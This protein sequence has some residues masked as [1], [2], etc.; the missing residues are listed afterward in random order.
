MLQQL[1]LVLMAR[2]KKNTADKSIVG[3]IKPVTT[4]SKSPFRIV[5]NKGKFILYHG[6]SVRQVFMTRAKAEE[7]MEWCKG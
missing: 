2:Q 1:E 5:E 7:Y 3:E 4:V 6:G